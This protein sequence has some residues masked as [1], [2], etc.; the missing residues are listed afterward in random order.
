MW[1]VL[2]PYVKLISLKSWLFPITYSLYRQRFCDEQLQRVPIQISCGGTVLFGLQETWDL[3]IALTI[4]ILVTH[5]NIQHCFGRGLQFDPDYLLWED[6]SVTTATISAIG[7]PPSFRNRSRT[8]K[9]LVSPSILDPCLRPR[10]LGVQGKLGTPSL[11]LTFS[12]LKMDGWNC[13]FH[14][15]FRLFS[16][17]N[18]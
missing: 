15:G 12:R 3:L 13:S 6:E 16:G 8:E 18:C 4:H 7:H 10:G 17:A 11:K 5:H 14:L 9:S 2:G 1:C